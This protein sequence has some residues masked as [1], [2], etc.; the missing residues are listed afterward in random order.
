MCEICVYAVYL[1][2]FYHMMSTFLCT[3]ITEGVFCVLREENRLV[4]AVLFHIAHVDQTTHLGRL[5]VF[6]LF[7]MY[8]LFFNNFA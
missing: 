2:V 3:S 4:I 6:I 1:H 7:C 8:F 5:A